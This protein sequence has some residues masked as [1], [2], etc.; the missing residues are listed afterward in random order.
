MLLIK[1][2]TRLLVIICCLFSGLGIALTPEGQPEHL[3]GMTFPLALAPFMTVYEDKELTK[4]INDVL[5]PEF[6]NEFISIGGRPLNSGLSKSAFWLR[7]ELPESVLETLLGMNPQWLLELD[8]P[9]MNQVSV[10]VLDR[11]K[12]MVV[13]EWQ[14]GDIYPFSKRPIPTVNFVFP[15]ALQDLTGLTLLIRLEND[16]LVIGNPRLWQSDDYFKITDSRAKLSGLFYGAML[17]MALYNFFIFLSIKDQTYL[18]YVFSIVGITLFDACN[19]GDALKYLWPDN[20]EYPNILLAQSVYFAEVFTM[21]F[22]YRFLKLDKYMKPWGQLIKGG[23]LACALMML[24]AMFLPN[25]LSINIASGI[26]MLLSVLA[27][28]I[29]VARVRMGSRSAKLF[30]LA[31]SVLLVAVFITGLMRFVAIPINVV[32]SNLISFGLCLEVVLL[33]IALADNFNRIQSEAKSTLR[34]AL[35]KLERSN[36]V[37]DQFLSTISHELRTPMNGIEG[38]LSLIN[39]EAI[40]DVDRLH[41]NTAASSAKDMT[42]MI[43]ALLRF[44]EMQAGSIVLKSEPFNPVSFFN[45]VALDIEDRCQRKDIAFKSDTPGSALVLKGDC[46]Q[47]RLILI[48]LADNAVKYTP[49]G[50][51]V[52]LRVFQTVSSGWASLVM[53]LKDTGVGMSSE[54][55]SHI[56]KPF[57]N[58]GANA[59]GE[60]GLGIGL[61]LSRYLIDKMGGT[62]LIESDPNSGTQ[63]EVVLHLPILAHE[64]SSAE[65]TQEE[66]LNPEKKILIVEDNPVNQQVLKGILS[67]LGYFSLVAGNGSE[68]V[69]M[70]KN[71]EIDIVF[72]DCQMPVMDGYEATHIL[73]TELGL[74]DLPVI[75]VTANAMSTDKD[76]CLKAGM[77]DYLAKPIQIEQIRQKLIRWS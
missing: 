26:A 19:R 43:D 32:T 1:F 45:D 55:Q 34:V 22:F 58:V 70:L 40:S 28:Y 24:V 49:K 8:T 14:T 16:G 57:S 23:T 21:L 62:L 25:R 10:Y 64:P 44:N 41:L 37:K 3:P 29:G 54:L 68:A 33:S 7:V 50:G 47:L 27:V 13:R 71:N 11:Q 69:D 59:R 73:R 30:L 52:E 42:S 2:S 61:T 48:Q 38:S 17:I 66:S 74:K 60:G 75:A 5:K 18:Y 56:F 9:F 46:D 53:R 35:D 36:L 76:R 65:P 6:Q 4:S 67:K 39:K 31:W 72:M 51:K 63:A 12:N 15:L 77:D 20:P